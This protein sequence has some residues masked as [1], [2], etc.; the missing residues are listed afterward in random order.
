MLSLALHLGCAQEKESPAAKPLPNDAKKVEAK[1]VP[2]GPNIL[3]EVD[4]ET[5]KV[6]VSAEVCRTMGP[7]E[8][9]LCRKGT[10]EHESVLIADIDARDLHKALMLA[11]GEPGSPVTFRPE[12][13][14]ATGSVIRITLMYEKDGKKLTVPAQDW[15]R[16]TKSMKALAH[17]W[18]FAGSRF[19]PDPLDK[20]KP[21]I[22][23]ANEGD[24]ICVSNF[25]SA[26]LDLPIESSKQNADVQFEAFTENI[27]PDGTKVA[28]CLEV[29]PPTTKK[30]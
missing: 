25:E 21:P 27:P 29:I 14:A 30:P 17:D 26:L 3:F 2:V 18:V 28:V 22:Y 13:K 11:R 6:W 10:K 5:R 4:G 19:V 16:D 7:L 15:V 1:K 24:V 23:L 9:L 8:Q 12:Y 20:N